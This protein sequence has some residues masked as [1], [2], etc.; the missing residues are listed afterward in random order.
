MTAPTLAELHPML[1]AEASHARADDSVI[2]E[3]KHD[4]YRCR[5]EVIGA[6]VEIRTRNGADATRWWPE[7]ARGLAGLT[8]TR[9]VLDGEACVLDDLGRSDFE[10]LHE[11]SRRRGWYAGAPV[12]IFMA[13]D[14]L[15][16]R[17]VDVR[18]EPLAQRK[19]QLAKLLAKPRDNV[20]LCQ[21]VDGSH[22]PELYRM[23]CELRLEGIVVKRLDSAYECGERSGAWV[24]VK[25]PGATPA[26]RFTRDMAI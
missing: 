25:R 24:K 5:V 15:W 13:F 2:A 23:A 4:G 21:H 14:L 22:A 8:K 20:L 3:L 1:L 18:G 7:V 6:R 10:S 19:A 12:V 9:T 11:R 17:G 26:E 16:L